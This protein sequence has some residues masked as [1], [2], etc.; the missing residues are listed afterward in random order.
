MGKKIL[1]LVLGLVLSAPTFAWYDRYGYWHHGW[2][3]RYVVVHH[4]RYVVVRPGY[5][6]HHYY[7]HYYHHYY[8]YY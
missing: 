4:P 5:W 3:P 1:A 6:H 8:R 2:G 7:R